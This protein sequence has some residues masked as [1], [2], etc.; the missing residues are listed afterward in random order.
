[1]DPT[2]LN[3]ANNSNKK[4]RKMINWLKRSIKTEKKKEKGTKFYEK[5]T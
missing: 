1:M 4:I 3:N 5:N 2:K